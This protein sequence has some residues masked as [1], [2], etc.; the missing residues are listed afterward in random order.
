MGWHGKKSSAGSMDITVAAYLKTQS[1]AENNLAHTVA[2]A[3][4]NTEA[5][6]TLLPSSTAEKPQQASS[7]LSEPRQPKSSDSKVAVTPNSCYVSQ[8]LKPISVVKIITGAGE[9]LHACAAVR[10][11]HLLACA[12]LTSPQNDSNGLTT[13]RSSPAYATV[14]RES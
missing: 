14:G 6:T 8:I 7:C 10:G 4:C 12:G 2:P 1:L 13:H 5:T 3:R 9:N 11:S